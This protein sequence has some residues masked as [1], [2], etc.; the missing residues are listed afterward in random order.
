[1]LHFFV[2]LSTIITAMSQSYA[3][4]EHMSVINYDTINY[5]N[6]MLYVNYEDEEYEQEVEIDIDVEIPIQIKQEVDEEEYNEEEY[7]EETCNL[8]YENFQ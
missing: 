6:N 4:F 5:F 8:S 2:C 1:M 3:N 7:D